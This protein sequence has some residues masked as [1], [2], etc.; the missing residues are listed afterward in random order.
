ME[1]HKLPHVGFRKGGKECRIRVSGFVENHR[2]AVVEADDIFAGGIMEL[3]DHLEFPIFGLQPQPRR[4]IRRLEFLAPRD[5]GTPSD[6]IELHLGAAGLP[7]IR[8]C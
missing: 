8:N 1:T 3:T 6:Y 5:P 2:I 7:T 4:G